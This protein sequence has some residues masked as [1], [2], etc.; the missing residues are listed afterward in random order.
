MRKSH[1]SP[2][3]RS[4]NVPSGQDEA[5]GFRRTPAVSGVGEAVDQR[6]QSSAARTTP[7]QSFWWI[8]QPRFPA[9]GPCRREWRLSAVPAPW[10]PPAGRKLPA[11]YDQASLRCGLVGNFA[12]HRQGVCRLV[13]DRGGRDGTTYQQSGHS[14]E[15]ERNSQ[16]HEVARSAQPGE[17]EAA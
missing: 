13:N 12:F 4:R 5:P 3:Q 14:G 16:S 9:R 6:I 15:N 1:T 7:S 10:S 8:L 17:D 11:Q 2:K